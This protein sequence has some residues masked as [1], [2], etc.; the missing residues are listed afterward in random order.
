MTATACAVQVILQAIVF[1]HARFVIL[2]MATRTGGRVTGRRPIH[3]IRVG[4]VAVGAGEV[5]AVIERLIGQAAVTET[6]RDPAVRR[7]TLA[8]IDGCGEVSRNHAGGIGP[9]VA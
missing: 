1:V 8:T 3:R 7:V 2:R 9:V 6:R 5:A 4:V